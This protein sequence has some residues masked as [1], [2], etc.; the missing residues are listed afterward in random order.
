M[1]VELHS[2]AGRFS[3]TLDGIPE[4]TKIPF[5]VPQMP[6]GTATIIVKTAGGEIFSSDSFTVTP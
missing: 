5:K 6:S 2:Q 3:A 4:Q 1:T